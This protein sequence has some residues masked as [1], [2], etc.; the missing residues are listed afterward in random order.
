MFKGELTEAG[1]RTEYIKMTN[2]KRTA[3]KKSIIQRLAMLKRSSS[4]NG[5]DLAWTKQLFPYWFVPNEADG[6]GQDAPTLDVQT[7]LS[8]VLLAMSLL[9][10]AELSEVQQ[11]QPQPQNRN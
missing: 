6:Q 3:M 7:T 8:D 2:T 4:G 10:Q 11:Q 1:P 9:V 5:V